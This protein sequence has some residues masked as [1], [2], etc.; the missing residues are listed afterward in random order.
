MSTTTPLGYHQPDVRR[1]VS[2]ACTPSP[3][4]LF[5]L[6]LLLETMFVLRRPFQGLERSFCF[7]F[8]SDLSAGDLP[9]LLDE[10]RSPA[11]FPPSLVGA[12]ATLA[13]AVWRPS[14]PAVLLL[15]GLLLTGGVRWYAQSLCRAA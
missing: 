14:P 6:S 2:F 1:S 10:D 8:A 7:G 4:P 12:G 5:L 13:Q 9:Q 3:S 15:A 11:R